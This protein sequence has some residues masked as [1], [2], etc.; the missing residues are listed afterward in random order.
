MPESNVIKVVR[1]GTLTLS[2]NGGANTYEIAYEDGNLVS[3]IPGEVVNNFL[4]RNRIGATPSLRFGADQPM[5]LS[6]TAN[7]RDISDAAYET[8]PE[9]LTRTG[10]VGSN[11]VGTLGANGEVPVYTLTWDLEGTGHGDPTDHQA[12]YPFCYLSGT[13]SEGDPDTIAMTI[14]SYAVRPSSVT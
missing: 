9:F 6:F 4:D 7:L 13:I 14:T 12:V 8:L 5:T 11:W 3:N 10:D 2:D 1:D